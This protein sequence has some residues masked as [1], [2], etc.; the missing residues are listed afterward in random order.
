MSEDSSQP[1]LFREYPELKEKIPW[2][3]LGMF[4][5]PVLKAAHLGFGNLWI[6]R[7]DIS[8][9]VYGGNKIRKLEFIL[10]ELKKK[11]ARHL[12]T[13]GGVGTHHGLAT[14]IF[15]R[16]LGIKCTV[17]MFKQPITEHVKQN[18]LLLQKHRARL[19]YCK[20]RW[21]TV[22]AYYLI[23][24][25]LHPLAGF[26]YAGGSNPVGTLGFVSAAF[27]L[28]NQI[29]QN[30]MPQPAVIICALGSCGTLA[31]LALGLRL[32]DLP[33]EIIG[34][35][36]T[37]S[38][39]GPFQA[40]TAGTVGKLMKSTYTYLKRK[41]P[42]ISKVAIEAPLI[43]EKYFGQGYGLPTEEGL[44]AYHLAEEKEN[45][46]LDP[47]YTA[48]TFAAVIDYCKTH[49]H[50]RPV[51]YWHTY[52]SVDLSAQAHSVDY[53]TLPTSLQRFIKEIEC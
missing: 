35:R 50:M 51:L 1:A 45:L 46:T 28:K 44:S 47:T 48:K 14:A 52:N 15:C 29:E 30:E 27:E 12:I 8:S 36:V 24:R 43:L 53:K 7:D 19:V 40:C 37:A 22:F 38:H 11:R 4:P 18:L 25:F 9:K 41:C 42:R 23:E 49:R 33:T 5:T 31:G 6:K 16:K 26:V 2:L 10:A 21:G 34:V 39:L 13:F 17:L 32:A 20:N 3:A